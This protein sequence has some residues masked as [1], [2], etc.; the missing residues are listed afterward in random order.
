M[1]TD[2]FIHKLILLLMQFLRATSE[3]NNIELLLIYTATD[4][5]LL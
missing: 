3:K 2:T 5:Q 1:C 4:E